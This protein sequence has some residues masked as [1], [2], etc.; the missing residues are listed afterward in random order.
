[1]TPIDEFELRRELAAA[2]PTV[3]TSAQNLGA[4]AIKRGKAVQRRRTGVAVVATLA[5][6]AGGVGLASQFLPNRDVQPAEPLPQV[7]VSPSTTP[8]AAE[9]TDVAPP[10]EQTVPQTD[11]AME[12]VTADPTSPGAVD[13]PPPVPTWTSVTKLPGEFGDMGGLAPLHW[14]AP[15]EGDTEAWTVGDEYTIPCGSGPLEIPAL[16]SVTAGKTTG[17]L[18]PESFSVESVLVFTDQDAAISFMQQLEAAAK[19]CVDA[20]PAEPTQADEYSPIIQTNRAIKWVPDLGDYALAYTSWDR[21]KI[22]ATDENYVDFPNG[23][24]SLWV[25]TGNVVAMA[26]TSG[27]F[28]G[29][30]MNNP[31]ALDWLMPAIDHVFKG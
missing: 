11:P 16:G 14:Q 27:E 1:M 8:T 4:S 3:G 21:G 9:S 26:D 30:P 15:P 17:A 22:E 18:G 25:R 13:A 29:N 28:V 19:A 24:I 20:G 10:P 6:V 23:S 5:L 7:T 12:P 31:E 2:E